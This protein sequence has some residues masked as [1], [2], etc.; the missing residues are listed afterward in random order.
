MTRAA[1]LGKRMASLLEAPLSL[2]DA[3]AKERSKERKRRSGETKEERRL[4][5]ADKRRR[6]AERRETEQR[7][8]AA[9]GRDS[10]P[11]P[12]PK[13]AEGFLRWLE[14]QDIEGPESWRC[15]AEAEGED[16]ALASQNADQG[17][18]RADYPEEEEEDDEKHRSSEHERDQLHQHS[19]KASSKRMEKHISRKRAR[20]RA[21][22]DPQQC[23]QLC[24]P[25]NKVVVDV[26]AAGPADMDAVVLPP[27]PSAAAMQPEVAAVARR[28]AKKAQIIEEEIIEDHGNLE[29]EEQGRN[30]RDDVVLLRLEGTACADKRTVTI[31]KWPFRVGRSEE[32]CDLVISNKKVSKQ[33]VL[34]HSLGGGSFEIE[35]EGKFGVE[36]NGT[37][38]AQHARAS[39]EAGASI[40]LD[41]KRRCVLHF[42]VEARS[43]YT[44]EADRK[45]SSR[46]LSGSASNLAAQSS[47]CARED[48]CDSGQALSRQ[49]KKML[50]PC[51]PMTGRELLQT[52]AQP[53][54]LK[55]GLGGKRGNL[56]LGTAVHG[57]TTDGDPAPVPR[58]PKAKWGESTFS[59]VV[60]PKPWGTL[61][62]TATMRL[63]D[64]MDVVLQGLSARYVGR[65]ACTCRSMRQLVAGSTFWRGFYAQLCDESV[66]RDVF[67]LEIPPAIWIRL[68]SNMVAYRRQM[69]RVKKKKLKLGQVRLSCP[70]TSCD[71]TFKDVQTLH[72]HLHGEH[73]STCPQLIPPHFPVANDGVRYF[74]S[75]GPCYRSFPL[76]H[77]ARRHESTC[78]LEA[79]LQRRGEGSFVCGE[80]GA[81]FRFKR[82]FD[83]HFVLRNQ[84]PRCPSQKPVS[85][86]D[87]NKDSWGQKELQLSLVEQVQTFVASHEDWPSITM[88]CTT[89]FGRPSFFV[90]EHP[91]RG[92]CHT[93][94]KAG[95]WRAKVHVLGVE[96]TLG[97]YDTSVEAAVAYDVYLLANGKPKYIHGGG[98]YAQPARPGDLNLLGLRDVEVPGKLRETAQHLFAAVKDKV[99][100]EQL[101]HGRLSHWRQD[102]TDAAAKRDAESQGQKDQRG[103]RT[104]ARFARCSDQL[105]Q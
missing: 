56:E 20:E 23:K 37:W 40:S 18:V 82:A 4:R 46:A 42:G 90:K 57:S 10:A 1:L 53:K 7:E 25:Q 35:V 67:R 55:D 102:L 41:K 91:I 60:Q 45:S 63:G 78:F 61:P 98:H 76:D 89:G 85:R 32:L 16:E 36:A 30:V 19:V 49:Q 65:L 103:K 24:S 81:S 88:A 69:R 104:R 86:E 74:C 50:E 66:S 93:K 77:Q 70:D 17:V 83:A 52:R 9:A 62:Q 48:D 72:S 29:D 5:K 99:A 95:R 59:T 11:A 21:P 101:V 47:G 80:C 51:A 87:A 14:Q 27:R 26:E 79:T 68:C 94:K 73:R 13:L 31:T 92:I 34:L 44:T 84:L 43:V 58:C 38:L 3:A 2:N 75:R 54:I 100:R 33:H 71:K 105:V 22:P 97:Y 15:P 6:K 8:L 39:L 96:V 28:V 12:P 64:A